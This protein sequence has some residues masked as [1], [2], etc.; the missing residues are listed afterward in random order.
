MRCSF[1]L[2]CVHV[3]IRFPEFMQF[4]V[5][6]ISQ[7]PLWGIFGE[8]SS[9]LE[10][11]KDFSW[12]PSR[13]CL[14]TWILFQ[15]KLRERF[16][17]QNFRIEYFLVVHDI[18]HMNFEKAA[19]HVCLFYL[20]VCFVFVCLCFY[21]LV[22]SSLF[23]MALWANGGEGGS[24][25]HFQDRFCHPCSFSSEDAQIQIQISFPTSIC[26]KYKYLFR[27]VFTCGQIFHTSGVS[28]GNTAM[29]IL[30]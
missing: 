12:V 18:E 26:C 8:P 23:S 10:V 13:N 28:F 14:P 17:R 15:H 3:Q 24:S 11:V 6:C 25:P 27:Q 2:I 30:K 29:Q 4:Q 21:V 5:L 16:K 1:V 19:V 7:G 20:L 9:L 22:F